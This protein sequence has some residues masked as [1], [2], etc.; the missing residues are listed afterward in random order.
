MGVIVDPNL[1]D[2]ND[3]YLFAAKELMKPLIYHNRKSPQY[4]ALYKPTDESV[5]MR[6]KIHY[7]VKMRGNAGYG[8]YEIAVKVINM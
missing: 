7:S 6:K 5:L 1:T 3:W 4:V 2:A 8:Y